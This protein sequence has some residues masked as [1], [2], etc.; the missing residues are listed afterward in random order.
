MRHPRPGKVRVAHLTQ[1]ERDDF[2]QEIG[3]V[4]KLL[5]QALDAM[6][7]FVEVV[8][9]AE[10]VI[11]SINL[12]GPFFKRVHEKYLYLAV[13]RFVNLFS[14]ATRKFLAIPGLL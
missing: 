13:R 14:T 10:F 4:G 11:G 12:V 5:E 1:S 9:P 3:I 6:V 8:A 7:S 2:I